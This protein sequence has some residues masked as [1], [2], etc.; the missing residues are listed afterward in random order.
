MD[1]IIIDEMI[2]VSNLLSDL[3]D[4]IERIESINSCINITNVFISI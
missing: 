3:L 1:L 4:K 2:I